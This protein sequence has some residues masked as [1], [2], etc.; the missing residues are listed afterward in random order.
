MEKFGVSRNVIRQAIGDLVD[1][2]YLIRKKAK[3]TFVSTPTAN[4]ERLSTQEAFRETVIRKG[5]IPVTKVLSMEVLDADEQTAELL[6]VDVGTRLIRIHRLRYASD[7]PVSVSSSYLPYAKCSFV[8]EHRFVSDGLHRVLS[9]HYETRIY[10]STQRFEARRAFD[11]EAA[12]LGID[13]GSVVQ[14]VTRKGYNRMGS[15]IEATISVYR[16]DFELEIET[17]EQT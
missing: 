15:V 7:V 10:R 2:G 6:N 1:G 11:D 4:V 13:S 17:I 16:G 14:C 12:L 5:D 9:Q 8:L 3:G